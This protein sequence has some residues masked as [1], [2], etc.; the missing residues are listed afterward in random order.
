MFIFPVF[1]SFWAHPEPK[2]KKC[3]W[4]CGPR[5]HPLS[6]LYPWVLHTHSAANVD[7]GPMVTLGNSFSR[8]S[9]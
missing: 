8:L 1:L 9:F 4:I 7:N 2:A 6:A 3:L 5:A